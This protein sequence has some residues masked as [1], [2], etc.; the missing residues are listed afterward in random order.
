MLLQLDGSEHAWIPGLPGR[1]T[2]LAIIDDATKAVYA[3]TLGPEETTRAVLALLR[4]V[5]E[6]Q[7]AFCSLYTDRASLFVTTRHREAP[8]QPRGAQ[9]PTQIAR[10]LQE[11]GIQ[12][13]LAHSPQ[14]KGHVERLFGTWQ[15]RLPQEL[16]LGGITTY[17]AANAQTWPRLPLPPCGVKPTVS[18]PQVYANVRDD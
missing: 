5:V 2:L 13:I 10:A 6:R 17:K 11:L 14:A 9:Y 7:G 1:Q 15:G 12:L 8:H 4:I 3:A 16:C 18:G